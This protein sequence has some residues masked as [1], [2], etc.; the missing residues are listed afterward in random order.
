MRAVRSDRVLTAVRTVL[1]DLGVPHDNFK[2]RQATV[3]ML[4]EATL[5]LTA[6]APQN[7]W[8][9]DEAPGMFRRTYLI[10]QAARL[11]ASMPEGQ[12]PLKF[13]EK[14]RDRPLPQDEIEDPFRKGQPVAQSAV[15]Q[16]DAALRV[17]LPAL[18]AI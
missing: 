1:E 13:L 8:I 16:I 12:D 9:V 15:E 10:K 3:P 5:I 11:L 7:E 2:S 18:G 14:T 17:I 6:S 4:H